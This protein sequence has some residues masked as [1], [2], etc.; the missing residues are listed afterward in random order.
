MSSNAE[1]GQIQI[2]YKLGQTCLIWTKRDP[3]D[4]DDLD[5]STQVLIGLWIKGKVFKRLQHEYLYE[6]FSICE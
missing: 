5:D 2:I 3:V 1:S 4:L 6:D